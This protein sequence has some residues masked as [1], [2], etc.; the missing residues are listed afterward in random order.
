M[1]KFILLLL[2]LVLPFQKCHHIFSHFARSITPA[3]LTIPTFFSKKLHFYFSD[4]LILALIAFIL[5]RRSWRQ[6]F[7]EG[8]SKYLLALIGVSFVS[9]ACSF[10]AHYPLQYLRVLEF[11]L[12]LSLFNVIV[13]SIEPK[14]FAAW[15][16][17]F[18]WMI[19]FLSLFESMIAILQYF[20][21]SALGLKILNESSLKGT[22][23]L[24]N[25]GKQRWWI[26]RLLGHTTDSALLSRAHGT[27][28][29]PNI[30]GGFILLSILN[31]LYLYVISHKNFQRV[32]MLLALFLQIF[33]LC[34]SFSRSAIY[35]FV[36]CVC[37]FI[38][39]CWKHRS[40]KS[41]FVLIGTLL[42]SGLTLLGIFLSQFIVRGGIINYNNATLG[43]DTE[44]IHYIKIALNMIKDHPFFGVGF[45][46]F[47]LCINDYLA[48]TEQNTLFFKVHNIYL[49]IA[50]EIGLIGLAF[51]LLFIFSILKKAFSGHWSLEKIYL[52][53][54]FL[55][56]LLIGCCDMYS[57]N[58]MQ[59]KLIF[60]GLAAFLYVVSLRDFHEAQEVKIFS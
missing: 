31:T 14:E 11:S 23:A 30:F 41:L 28:G 27:F 56:V 45:N 15:I 10:T 60:F 6:F 16:R 22:L 44:R 21:Q 48:S 2:F 37:V 53:S 3:D 25:P 29:H 46:N 52:F 40:S 20:N 19:L 50:S 59:A 13:H 58:S 43:A 18:A 9:V 42:T 47:Q 7:W 12:V 33:A 38:G 35:A 55:G 17:T 39:L 4:A 54:A 1:K 24:L 8:P 5:F 57:L 34:V 36:L 51:F 26:D 49:L 32:V